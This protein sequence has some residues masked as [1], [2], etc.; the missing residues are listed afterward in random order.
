M[1]ISNIHGAK[2]AIRT[3]SGIDFNQ[4]RSKLWTQKIKKNGKKI[5]EKNDKKR[6]C[7]PTLFSPELFL[8]KGSFELPRTFTFILGCAIAFSKKSGLTRGSPF[9]NLGPIRTGR[10][11]DLAARGSLLRSI[12]PFQIKKIVMG[13]S[14][15][16]IRF[17]GLIWG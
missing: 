14:R 7:L 17:K 6:S 5:F 13:I 8:A 1:Y 12:R 2:A 11:L 10:L 4:D 9:E 3:V 15:C 16:E